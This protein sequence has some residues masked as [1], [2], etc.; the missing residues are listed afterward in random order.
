MTPSAI[1]VV[2]H[3]P[4]WLSLLLLARWRRLS[5]EIDGELG[6]VRWGT[7]TFAVAPGAHVVVVGFV[8]RPK[9]ELTVHVGEHETVRVRY[10]PSVTRH[11][12]GTLELDPMP[13]AQLR[14]R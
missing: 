4:P 10:T 7:H 8:M 3:A 1:E 5:V 12:R 2:A 14:S 9:A 11:A 13:M 6:R